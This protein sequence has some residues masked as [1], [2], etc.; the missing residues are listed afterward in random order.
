MTNVLLFHHALGMTPGI[1]SFAD[2]LRGAGHRVV[3]PDLF[4]GTTF[5]S[6]EDGVAHAEAIG[7]EVLAEQ[8]AAHADEMSGEFVVAGFSLGVLPAQRLA[9]T[10]PG[11]TGA[12]FYHAAVPLSVFG[13]TW[14]AGVPVQLHFTEDDPWAVDDLEVAGVIAAEVGGQLLVHPGSGHLVAD[15]GSPDH[16]PETARRILDD[17][18]AFLAAVDTAVDTG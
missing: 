3:V 10:H 6:I 17:T 8:G 5:D 11:V 9:Q 13:G 15:P 1:E 4:E 18:L 14:P 7:F 2:L 16:D 12:V